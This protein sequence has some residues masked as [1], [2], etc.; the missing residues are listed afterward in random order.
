MPGYVSFFI[1]TALAVTFGRT[2][3]GD[4]NNGSIKGKVTTA[5]GQPAAFV[6]IQVKGYNKS[7]LTDEDGSFALRGLVPGEYDLE[8]TLTGYATTVQ[9][10]VVELGKVTSVAIQLL[11]YGRQLQEVVVTGGRNKFARTSRYGWR[12][13]PADGCRSGEGIY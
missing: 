10:V 1:M 4:E 3:E 2:H 7:T 9:H 8:I 11:V 12:W 6:T 5:D 13:Q